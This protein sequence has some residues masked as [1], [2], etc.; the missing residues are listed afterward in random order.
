MFLLTIYKYKSSTTIYSIGTAVKN[1]GSILI[2]LMY[3]VQSF[4]RVVILQY[5][6][7]ASSFSHL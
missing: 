2:A 3:Q 6:V 1:N 5:F 7:I 4:Y